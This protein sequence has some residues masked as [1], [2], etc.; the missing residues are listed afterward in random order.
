MST[1]ANWTI[2]LISALGALYWLTMPPD[3]LV[4]DGSCQLSELP[5][6]LSESLYG[7]TFW[8]GQQAALAEALRSELDLRARNEQRQD[9]PDEGRSRI[10]R[11]MSRLSERDI[12]G[13]Q[14]AAA[15]AQR[16]QIARMAWLS[17]CQQVIEQNLAR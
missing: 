8:K 5:D 16:E 10:D 3:D 15:Q 17:R 14:Q 6:R 11:Q 7:K 9:Q 12:S 4:L 13:D 2:G 1:K